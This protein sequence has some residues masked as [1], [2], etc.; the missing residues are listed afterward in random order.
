VVF[1][2]TM[3]IFGLGV[4]AT[5]A[6]AAV[7]TGELRSIGGGPGRTG[8]CLDIPGGDSDN[9]TSVRLYTLCNNTSAQRFSLDPAVVGPI[10]VLGKCVDVQ[11]GGT[12]IGAR[13]QIW[14]CNN[15]GAQMW[16]PVQ[17]I[18]GGG[19]CSYSF[20]NPQSGLCLHAEFAFSALAD[21]SLLNVDIGK[22]IFTLNGQIF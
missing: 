10:R 15:T 18:C 2:L 14:S 7:L 21:C 6:S 9:G 12:H 13:I 17:Q 8:D 5:P 16:Q 3:T 22:R 4:A 19:T 1:A 20:R 11:G